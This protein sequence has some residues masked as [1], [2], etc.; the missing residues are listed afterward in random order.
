MSRMSRPGSAREA[1]IL[2]WEF[3]AGFFILV[4]GSVLHFAFELS[5]FWVAVAPF[6]A[7]NESIWE[8]LKLAFWPALIFFAVQF[9]FLKGQKCAD[10]FWTAKALCLFLM[11][12]LIAAGWY[13]VVA[14]TGDHYFMVDI[15]LFLGAIIVGQLLSY[16]ILS[17]KIAA[18]PRPRLAWALILL[19]AL[20]FAIFSFFPP[21]ISLFEH[22]TLEN[23]G[24]Y[25]ILQ[26]VETQLP[27]PK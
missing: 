10:Q 6:A 21:K 19:I 25:G 17:G 24:Q 4:F 11:P 2:V 5:N 13:A 3:A 27:S 14:L 9:Y 1:N 22:S 23:S 26:Q 15:A 8:H 7:V 12:F 16:A 18:T 20:A